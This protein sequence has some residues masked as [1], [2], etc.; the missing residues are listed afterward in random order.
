MMKPCSPVSLI[1]KAEIF[2]L[3]LPEPYIY[4]SMDLEFGKAGKGVINYYLDKPPTC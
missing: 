2:K 1:N 4:F 3:Q